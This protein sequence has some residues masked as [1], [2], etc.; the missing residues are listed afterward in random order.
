MS[1]DEHPKKVLYVAADRLERIMLFLKEKLGLD[2]D[3]AVDVFGAKTKI[4]I[5]GYAGVLLNASIGNYDGKIHP[6]RSSFSVGEKFLG[7]IQVASYARKKG[8]PVVV[9][10]N[11]LRDTNKWLARR[12]SETGGISAFLD[13]RDKEGLEKACKE[14][15][16]GLS[17]SPAEE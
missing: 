8:L 9:L 7:A 15:F 17:V 12:F 2:Y 5:V 4:D 1:E 11:E 14:F 3:T 16:L 6:G 13:T 10:T